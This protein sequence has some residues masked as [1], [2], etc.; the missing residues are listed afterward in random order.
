MALIPDLPA[1]SSLSSTDLV[2]IDT[3]SQTKKITVADFL[4][5]LLPSP[6]TGTITPASGWALS[7]YSYLKKWGGHIVEFYAELTGGTYSINGWNDV[8]TLPTGFRPSTTFDF[9]G[10][11]N[12]ASTQAGL[13]LDCKATSGGALRVY[14]SSTMT[15]TNN[16]RLHGTFI[17]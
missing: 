17:V 11:D 2:V 12:G 1:A 16:I 4:S 8:A 7:S 14:K 5:S 9:I 3:G 10:L 13:G 15:P 6:A